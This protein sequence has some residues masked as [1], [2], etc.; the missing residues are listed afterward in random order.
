MI[1]YIDDCFDLINFPDFDFTERIRKEFYNIDNLLEKLYVY[2]RATQVVL[3]VKNPP[4]IEEMQADVG[5]VSG[6]GRFP[7]GGHG[8]PFQ[9][10]C[11][12][13]LRG[14]KSLVGYR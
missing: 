7:R 8:N 10:S 2:I 3:V 14:H 9:Y 4:A 11:L 6:L 1:D 13:N 5:S 12:E